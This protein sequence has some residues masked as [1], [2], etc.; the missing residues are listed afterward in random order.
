MKAEEVKDILT[1]L[2]VNYPQSFTG[3]TPKM[4]A[5]LLALWTKAFEKDDTRLVNAAVH[6]IIFETTNSFVPNVGQVKA[7]MVEIANGA[8]TDPEEAFQR[9]RNA[10]RNLESDRPDECMEIYNAL[11]DEIRRVCTVH[12]LIDYAFH[13]TSDE[14][15]N[16]EKPRFLR[17]IR[18]T[19][20][21][22]A[23]QLVTDTSKLMIPADAPKLIE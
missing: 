19:R 22:T 10:V 15:I 5:A 13:M 1:V 20:E 18:E 9:L 4:G 2:K 8:T 16:Y 17:A 11:P 23:A 7:K 6:A 3:Y 21:S 12:D 14:F